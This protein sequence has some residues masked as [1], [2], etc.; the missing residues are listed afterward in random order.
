MELE[1]DNVTRV[2]KLVSAE[3]H[4]FYVGKPLTHSFTNRI[5]RGT[6]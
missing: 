2:V 1:E 4:E 5:T 6:Y 3:G